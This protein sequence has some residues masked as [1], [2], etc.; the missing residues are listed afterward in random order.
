MLISWDTY[1][2]LSGTI[3]RF[4]RRQRIGGIDPITR[5]LNFLNATLQTT[6]LHC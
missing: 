2:T 5:L 1:V 4:A 3:R 6:T